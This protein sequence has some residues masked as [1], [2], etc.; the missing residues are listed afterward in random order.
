MFKFFMSTLIKILFPLN[1]NV[2]IKRLFKAII[3]IY[4]FIIIQNFHK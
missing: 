3:L 2:Y 4:Y 1:Q